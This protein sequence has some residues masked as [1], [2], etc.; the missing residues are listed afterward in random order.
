MCLW[1]DQKRL[2]S[3]YY[4]ARFG[5]KCLM[6]LREKWAWTMIWHT[7]LGM[8]VELVNFLLLA[9][10]HKQHFL[11]CRYPLFPLWKVINHNSLWEQT[12]GGTGYCFV[13]KFH[14]GSRMEGARGLPQR[15]VLQWCEVGERQHNQPTETIGVSTLQQLIWKHTHV[16][17]T[18]RLYI[19]HMHAQT[20]KR[21]HTQSALNNQLLG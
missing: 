7:N 12:L 5:D 18:I 2:Q 14:F 15:G 20:A 11:C 17:C 19:Y 1:S 4:K 21:I 8:N 10:F 9:C 16:V 3:S 13:I 6:A